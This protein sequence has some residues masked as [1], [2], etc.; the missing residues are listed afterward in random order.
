MFDNRGSGGNRGG[1]G[2]SGP[3]RSDYGPGVRDRAPPARGGNNEGES[4]SQGAGGRARGSPPPSDR[5]DSREGPPPQGNRGGQKR[6]P[7]EKGD[8][9]KD[10]KRPRKG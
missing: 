6:Y 7:D 2:V 1:R 5:G 4:Q 9:F 10:A 8:N 3:D